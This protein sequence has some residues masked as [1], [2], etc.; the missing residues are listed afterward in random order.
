[1]PESRH[2]VWEP[3]NEDP[4][5]G[6]AAACNSTAGSSGKSAWRCCKSACTIPG[7]LSRNRPIGRISLCPPALTRPETRLRGQWKSN[8]VPNVNKTQAARKLY[9]VNPRILF[10]G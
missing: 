1:M 6:L 2:G 8:S 4:D 3:C 5:D 7:A 9:K 10:N